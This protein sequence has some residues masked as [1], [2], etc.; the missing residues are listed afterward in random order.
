[1]RKLVLF[2]LVIFFTIIFI[3]LSCSKNESASEHNYIGINSYKLSSVSVFDLIT[4][5]VD[6]NEYFLNLNLYNWGEELKTELIS[7]QNFYNQIINDLNSDAD[8]TKSFSS[9]NISTVNPSFTYQG[10]NYIP[11]LWLY[12]G[13]SNNPELEGYL[14]LATE[15][16]ANL[17]LGSNYNPKDFI[18][19]DDVIPGWYLDDTQSSHII[20]FEEAQTFENPILIITFVEEGTTVDNSNPSLLKTI[21]HPIDPSIYN[22]RFWVKN[23][24][25]N[26]RNDKSKNSEVR[27]Q[28]SLVINYDLKNPEGISHNAVLI[29]KN[30]LNSWISC[31]IPVLWYDYSQWGE[32]P[33]PI[34]NSDEVQILGV[35]YEFD[36]WRLFYEPIV[37]AGSNNTVN[38]KLKIKNSNDVYEYF[39]ETNLTFL[40]NGDYYT[41]NHTK[42]F[43]DE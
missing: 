38:Y 3:G 11:Y 26:E 39:Y 32:I 24:N 7:N 8:F 34:V 42:I 41:S 35:V 14:C 25:I 4:D 40:S 28:Y 10:I 22:K 18:N 43:Q 13:G 36:W 29:H 23:F 19:N 33:Q 21:S 12:N 6:S 31:T 2:N 15:V 17:A 5:N 37:I 20:S 30:D 27:I 16:D 9:L 1:M